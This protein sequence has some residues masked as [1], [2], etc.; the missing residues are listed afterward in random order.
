MAQGNTTEES[1]LAI[2]DARADAFVQARLLAQPL[3]AYPGT[4]PATLAEA[5]AIQN[6]AIQLWPDKVAGWK[7]GRINPPWDSAFGTD[8]LAGPI[9]ASQLLRAKSDPVD[10]FIFQG[11]FG[12]VESEVVIVAGDDAP[13]E[14]LR[15]NLKEAAEI[16]GSMHIG[17]EIASSCFAEIN[18][19]GPLVTISDFGN[20]NGLILGDEIPGWRTAALADWRLRTLIDGSEVGRADATAIPGG[21]M[22]SFR[23]LLEISAARGLPLRKGMLASTG[24]VT[25]VHA[26]HAGQT[27]T[28]EFAGLQTIHLR[29]LPAHPFN[30]TDNSPSS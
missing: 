27:A 1:N 16:A 3:P 18:E 24:A 11:G 28:V 22:E 7:V 4:M 19:H 17:A 15:W 10:C 23:Q 26:A 30:Q 14:K 13:P 9:F 21:P 20:N 2:A 8:R 5:Y 12:A 29:L 6:R 25:G